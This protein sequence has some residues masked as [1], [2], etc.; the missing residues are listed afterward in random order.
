MQGSYR[1]FEILFVSRNNLRI[2]KIWI[3]EDEKWYNAT[4]S[5]TKH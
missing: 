3:F 2:T 4:I 5:N 1:Q